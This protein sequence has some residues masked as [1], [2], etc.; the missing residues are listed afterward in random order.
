MPFVCQA[1]K[2]QAKVLVARNLQDSRGGKLHQSVLHCIDLEMLWKVTSNIGIAHFLPPRLEFCA[3]RLRVAALGTT[4]YH[5]GSP[6]I[7][8]VLCFFMM[9]ASLN[10]PH[11]VYQSCVPVILGTTRVTPYDS[12]FQCALHFPALPDSLSFS[13]FKDV[14][15]P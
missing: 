2:K 11:L 3:S 7:S 12:E 13:S 4:L 5:L 9:D 10:S 8:L 1:Q 14:D 15:M 6:L